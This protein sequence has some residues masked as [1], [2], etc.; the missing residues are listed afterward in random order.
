LALALLP[1]TAFAQTD[2]PE[3]E[4]AF[5]ASFLLGASWPVGTMNLHFDPGFMAAA[6][7]LYALSPMTRVG[8][9][10]GFYSFDSEPIPA[11]RV[12]NEG[13]VSLS[14]VATARGRSGP[15]APFALVGL[16]G[17]L[18]KDQ[19]SDGRRWDGGMEFGVGLSL[20]VSEHFAAVV[21]TSFHMIFRGRKE[22][23]L[24]LVRRLPWV[25]FEAALVT[26]AG[27]SLDVAHPERLARSLLRLVDIAVHAVAGV[28][29]SGSDDRSDEYRQ[30]QG[31]RDDG[32]LFLQTKTA[33][34][35]DDRRRRRRRRGH[36]ARQLQVGANDGGSRARYFPNLRIG[37]AEDL[38]Y[39]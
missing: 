22:R 11:E 10:L 7:G 6:R 39:R 33:R 19:F 30:A 36:A 34:C 38:L 15:Y 32:E 28:E 16:G 37:C 14:L 21:G 35:P 9:Q 17:Y 23:R 31:E 4:P 13:I 12:D 8:A 5:H 27:M 2:D 1:A 20:G 25:R 29:E 3:F 18:S 24:L 26:G